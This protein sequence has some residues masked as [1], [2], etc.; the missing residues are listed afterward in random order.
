MNFP[1]NFITALIFMLAGCSASGPSVIEQ[2]DSVA[3][4][5]DDLGCYTPSDFSRPYDFSGPFDLLPARDAEVCA[6]T[7][8]HC[9]PDEQCLSTPGGSATCLKKC[10]TTEQCAP[11]L[12]CRFQLYPIPGLQVCSSNDLPAP[13]GPPAPDFNCTDLGQICEDSKHV[14]RP[15]VAPSNQ[16]C[17]FEII[18]CPNGCI[19]TPDMGGFLGGKSGHC[20]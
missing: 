16:T 6:A 13:C 10:Q 5:P 14:R 19:S 12:T 7:C 3:C 15:F 4:S 1:G 9:A 18:M 2:P 8:A 20:A 11:G 17:G